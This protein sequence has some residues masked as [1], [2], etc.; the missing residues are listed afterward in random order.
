M[1]YLRVATVMPHRFNPHRPRGGGAMV[2]KR[3]TPFTNAF[4]SS[5]PPRRRYNIIT[6]QN[7]LCNRCFNPHRPG[8]A[9]Q[10]QY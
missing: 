1:R 10:R 6:R 2:S 9:V 4:Q 7:A 8:E 3:G 5:P